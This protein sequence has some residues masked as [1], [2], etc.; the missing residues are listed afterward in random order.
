MT[1]QRISFDRIFDGYEIHV[2]ASVDVSSGSIVDLSSN[3]KTKADHHFPGLLTPGFVDLQVNGGGGVLLNTTPSRDGIQVITEAHR[4]FGT[5]ALMPTVIT[6]HPDVMDK[7]AEAAIASRNDRSVIGLHIEGPHI[8]I[9]RRGTHAAEFIRPLDDRT[10]NTVHRLREAGVVVKITLAPEAATSKQVAKLVRMGAI[11]SMGHTDAT[12]EQIVEAFAAGASCATH[13]FNAMSPMT[14]RAPGAVGA[15]INSDCYAGIICDGHHLSD[16]MIGLAI[17]A[18]PVANRMFLVS[19]AMTTVGGPD[20]FDLYGQT[21]KLDDGRLINTEGSLAGAHVTQAQGVERLVN[22]VG[23]ELK[24]ALRMATS[25][26][27]SC[28]GIP[29]LGNLVGRTLEDVIVLN[30]DLTLRASLDVV[31]SDLA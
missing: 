14:G 17:R 19:D 26:P 22:K 24:D 1:R 7:A 11:V 27:A 3:T 10:L 4:T 30:D 23:I 5:T 6:D 25:T 20:H 12:A 9:A 2:N 28:I 29:Q 16:E 13:L 31:C 18:R 15:V 8:A 21:I